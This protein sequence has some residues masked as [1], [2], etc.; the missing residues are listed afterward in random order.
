VRSKVRTVDIPFGGQPAH[1]PVERGE[2]R[3][4]GRFLLKVSVDHDQ[5]MD[6]RV[7]AGIGVAAKIDVPYFTH[8]AGL[9]GHWGEVQEDLEYR[10][11]ELYPTLNVGQRHEYQGVGYELA[12][13][14]MELLSGKAMPVLSK[15]LLI[16]PLGLAHS[17]FA[18]DD[19]MT[20]RFAVGHNAGPDGTLAVARPWRHWRSGNPGGGIASSAADQLRWARFHLGDGRGEGGAGRPVSV[21]DRLVVSSVAPATDTVA[22]SFFAGTPCLCSHAASARR[23]REAAFV[24]RICG[25]DWSRRSCAQSG[26]RRMCRRHAPD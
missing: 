6:G 11:A 13:K 5:S 23:I 16:G 21:S 20:R 10:I 2:L 25:F 17:L 22:L 18:R 12:G 15:Q 3:R 4:R 9:Q 26:C 24:V 8:T 14:V 7:I 1:H 19:V